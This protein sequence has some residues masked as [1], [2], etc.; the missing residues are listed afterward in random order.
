[1]G[2]HSLFQFPVGPPDLLVSD[3]QCVTL[4]KALDN[5]IEVNADRVADERRLARAVDVAELRHCKSHY[6]AA[7][8]PFST[9]PASSPVASPF[10]RATTPL[11]IV[12][13][14]PSAFC[15]RRRAPPGR[16]FS[17]FGRG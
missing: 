3:D 5:P 6:E 14:M 13:A 15:T 1:E 17:T 7:N 2:V 4:A 8:R 12:A 10:S 9:R 11:T 16:S